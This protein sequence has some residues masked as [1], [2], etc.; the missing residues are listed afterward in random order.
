MKFYIATRLEQ[1]ARHRQLAHALT[2]GGHVLTYDWT[3][4]GN[5]RKDGEVRLRE[6][7]IAETRGVVEADVL[8]GL[9]P[10]GRGTHVE[11]GMALGLGKPVLLW[12]EKEHGLFEADDRTC[13]FYHH[14]LVHRIGLAWGLCFLGIFDTMSRLPVEARRRLMKEG[15][16]GP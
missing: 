15:M 7:A 5:V 14:P 13:A 12:S 1:A 6:T 4:H 8:I 2:G 9:L 3:V 16:D 10:G 11:I